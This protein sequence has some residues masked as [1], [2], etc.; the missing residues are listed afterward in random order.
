MPI[1][2]IALRIT[3]NHN[4]KGLHGQ[5]THRDSSLC[6][7]NNSYMF[8]LQF[9]TIVQYFLNIDYGYLSDFM[10]DFIDTSYVMIEHNERES[11]MQGT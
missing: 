4:L 11:S 7:A 2:V 3:F 1:Q 5:N 10:I 8:L 9:F 6:K